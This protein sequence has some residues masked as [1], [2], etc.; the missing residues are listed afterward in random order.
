MKDFNFLQ[1]I[2]VIAII[3]VGLTAGLWLNKQVEEKMQKTVSA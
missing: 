2:V 3:A 1:A